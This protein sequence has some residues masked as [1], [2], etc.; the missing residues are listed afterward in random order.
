MSGQLVQYSMCVERVNIDDGVRL[1]EVETFN[2][3]KGIC[4]LLPKPVVL[5]L[6]P[7]HPIQLTEIALEVS[8]R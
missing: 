1:I 3:S 6:A 4:S 7:P 5:I 2:R 8:Y